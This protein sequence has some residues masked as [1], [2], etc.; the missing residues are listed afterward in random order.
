M[1]EDDTQNEE[2]IEEPNSGS[3]AKYSQHEEGKVDTEMNED[4]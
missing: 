1:E 4:V 3:E 2:K